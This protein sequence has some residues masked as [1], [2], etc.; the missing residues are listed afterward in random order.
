M[1]QREYAVTLTIITT[2]ERSHEVER[3]MLAALDTAPTIPYFDYVNVEVVAE[4]FEE[5]SCCDKGEC[6][7]GSLTG[8]HTVKCPQRKD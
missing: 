5:E 8:Y 3:V 2:I 6:T 1:A 4:P 7:C